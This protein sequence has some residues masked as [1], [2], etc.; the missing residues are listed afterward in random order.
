MSSSSTQWLSSQDSF[1]DVHVI[2]GR[3][4]KGD[5]W[6]VVVT[7][8]EGL[9][10]LYNFRAALLRARAFFSPSSFPTT[11]AQR[12]L[13]LRRCCQ[14]FSG[15]TPILAPRAMHFC[16][17][18]T[19]PSPER[20]TAELLAVWTCGPKGRFA[21]VVFCCFCMVAWLF[22]FVDWFEGL[23]CLGFSWRLW[24]CVLAFDG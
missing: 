11:L 2:F 14:D 5:L 17:R 20:T 16:G 22:S 3:S 21:Y 23:K 15:S 6:Y 18:T 1:I 9:T 13:L 7:S 24:L 12:A 10:C 8:F 19:Q 4:N